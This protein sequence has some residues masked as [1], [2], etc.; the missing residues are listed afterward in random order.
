M[1]PE[2]LLLVGLAVTVGLLLTACWTGHKAKRKPHLVFVLLTVVAL[3]LTVLQAEYV[4]TL[5]DLEAAGI[6]TPIHLNIAY[7]ATG[8][9]LLPIITGIMTWR[10]PAKKKLHRGCVLI[11]VT[12]TVA[13]AITGALML[14]SAEPL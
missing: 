3:T 4:G 13:S 8:S 6:I 12:L 1:S 2:T 11:A 5:Y 7:V 10:N 14:T 9:F